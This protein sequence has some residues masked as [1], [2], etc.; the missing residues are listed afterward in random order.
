MSENL[1]KLIPHDPQFVPAAT[2]REVAT[3]LLR[4]LF[5]HADGVS[6]RETA[7]VEFI[8][9]GGNF[10]GVACPRCGAALDVDWWGDAVD[11]AFE[12]CFADLD[13]TLPCCSATCSLNDLRYEMPAGFSRFVLE[14]RNPG[15]DLTDAEVE[16]LERALGCRLRRVWARY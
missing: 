10:E 4:M 6:A 7:A 11:A 2:P 1:L 15:R 5:L 12:G 9:Q 8:D 16:A 14:A 3:V 13:V